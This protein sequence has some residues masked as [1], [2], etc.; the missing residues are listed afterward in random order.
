MASISLAIEREQ[1]LLLAQTLALQA[2]TALVQMGI[3]AGADFRPVNSG[4]IGGTEGA[5]ALL[6]EAV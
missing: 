1:L 5:Q 2:H 4:L 6:L 3:K